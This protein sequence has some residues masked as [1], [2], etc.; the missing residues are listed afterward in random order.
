MKDK[1]TK[2]EAAELIG[3]SVSTLNKYLWKR[4]IR[5][6]KYMGRVYFDRKDVEAFKRGLVEVRSA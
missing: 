2:A 1:M 6:Y 3:C 4:L 5:S